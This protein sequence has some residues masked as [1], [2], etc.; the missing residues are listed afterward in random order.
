MSL[1][2]SSELKNRGK[3]GFNSQVSKGRTVLAE[4]I[5]LKHFS[6]GDTCGEGSHRIEF[7][8][9]WQQYRDYHYSCCLKWM[10]G[11]SDDAEESLSQ[12]M[13][14]AWSKW[15]DHRDQ[16]TYPK[17]WLTQVIHNHCMDIHRQ[18]QR[19]AQKMENIDDINVDHIAVNSS[20]ESPES[21]ISRCEMRAYLNKAIESLPPR[22]RDPFILRYFQNKSC[23]DISKQ[24]TLSEENVWK[25]VQQARTIL[26]NQLNKYLTGE[27]DTSFD[28]LLPDLKSVIPTV[29]E[30]QPDETVIFDG[31]ASITTTNNIEE[32]SYKFTVLCIQTLPHSWYSSPSLQGWK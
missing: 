1:I 14:K 20:G 9:L 24:L 3:S 31:E 25:R 15:P 17:A 5:G 28:S 16:I 32:I 23:Q 4:P 27:D 6:Q 2:L 7:W 12:A 21:N 18:R 26:R 8:Q 30:S 11:N 19:E 22:L 10:N 29:K 13:L